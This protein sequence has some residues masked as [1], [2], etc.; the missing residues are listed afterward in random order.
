VL[1][2]LLSALVH[3]L[4]WEHNGKLV[5]EKKALNTELTTAK[6]NVDAQTTSAK[7]W[8]KNAQDCA[9]TNEELTAQKA[10]LQQANAK[11]AA[12]V[13]IVQ[14]T[15][16]KNLATWQKKYQAAMKNGTCADILNTPLSVCPEL[17]Q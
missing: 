14:A 8:Q 2:L 7:G 4:Q 11:A 1:A 17:T 16:Q 5:A 9:A 6:G 10:D 12:Q 15:A 13:A 3:F